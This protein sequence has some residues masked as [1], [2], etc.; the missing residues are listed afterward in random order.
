MPSLYAYAGLFAVLYTVTKFT[1]AYRQA[2]KLRAIPAV[3]PTG[4]LSSY[5]G[6]FRFLREAREMVQEG[7]DQYCGTAFRVPMLSKWMIVLSGPRMIDDI[8]K[9]TDDQLSFRDALSESFH[10]DLTIGPQLHHDP[11][12]V[13]IVR[14][15]LTRNLAARFTEVQ[16]EIVT[17]FDDLIPGVE[18]DWVAVPALKTMMKIVCRTSNRLFVGLPLCRDPDFTALMERFSLDVVKGGNTLNSLPRIL[19]PIAVRFFTNVPANIKRA[20][21][22]IAPILQ[23]RLEKE[24][25]HG[26]DWPGKPNDLISWLLEEAEGEQRTLWDISVRVLAVNFAAI[27][28]T[29]MASTHA[30]YDLAVH[31]EYIK[32][33]REEVEAVIKEDGWSKTAMGK[34]RKLD[35]FLRESQ[36]LTGIGAL[37][38]NRKV[39]KDFT[40]SDGTLVPAGNFVS[41]ASFATHHNKE[42]YKNPY[43]FDGFRFSRLREDQGEGTKHQTVFLSS[44]NVMFGGGRHACPGR[45]FA[46]N[47]LKAILAYTLITYDVKLE[48]GTT[49]PPDLWVGPTCAPNPTAK[50]ML[51]RRSTKS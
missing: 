7:Y 33:L 4:M 3:G 5:P 18:K 25:L 42:Y 19:W 21:G 43:E 45:F 35:S 41:V 26:R 48:H 47:E 24:E 22:H 36:R 11:Y 40:F 14:T 49:R 15:P 6:A 9:A 12:H 13:A 29:S 8:R 51:R 1:S 23:D 50:I 10:I 17:S 38:M 2:S 31:P 20:M 27:H 34:M 28:T 37:V 30:L 32:P 16:N 44:E 46:V 39:L